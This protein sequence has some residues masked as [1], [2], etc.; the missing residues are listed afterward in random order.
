M[1]RIVVEIIIN[2]VGAEVLCVYALDERTNQLEPVAAEGRERSTFV[3]G[4]GRQRCRSAAPSRSGEIRY[5]EALAGA[6]PDEPLVCIP[7]CVGEKSIG[8]IALFGL[9]VQKERFTA[10]DHELFTLLGGH[11]ATA[12]LAAQL[13]GQSERKLNTMQGL[14][15]LLTQK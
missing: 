14:I 3:S 4:A 1:L 8:A 7:L 12:I 11:A 5:R 10:L 9:L 2:L 15:G 6:E 13:H